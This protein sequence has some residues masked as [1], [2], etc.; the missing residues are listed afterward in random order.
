MFQLRI[1][2]VYEHFLLISHIDTKLLK[3]HSIHYNPQTQ[4]LIKDDFFYRNCECILPPFVVF[5][6]SLIELLDQEIETRDVKLH[7]QIANCLWQEDWQK[8]KSQ[9]I[10]KSWTTLKLFTMEKLHSG[11]QKRALC[12]QLPSTCMQKN[13]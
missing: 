6:W 11:I 9:H 7:T 1:W 8:K 3:I 13:N 2:S 4:Q 5:F 10:F 12:E